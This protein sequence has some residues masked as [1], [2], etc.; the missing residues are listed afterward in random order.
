MH[1]FPAYMDRP[2]DR[3]THGYPMGTEVTAYIAD[4]STYAAQEEEYR[5]RQST[6]NENLWIA[7]GFKQDVIGILEQFEDFIPSNNNL[8]VAMYVE[9]Q[10]DFEF[11]KGYPDNSMLIS[12]SP[13]AAF[14]VERGT[15]EDEGVIKY[16]YMFQN[17]DATSGPEFKSS[18][19]AACE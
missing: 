5:T 2:D 11:P 18:T 15:S 9:S 14:S 12:S 10:T 1:E 6:D 19:Y 4:R 13:E 3:M 8:S 17:V 7:D 16:A